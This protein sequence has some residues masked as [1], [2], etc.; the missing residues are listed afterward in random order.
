MY[1][2]VT[3]G[4]AMGV[5]LTWRIYANMANLNSECSE[6]LVFKGEYFQGNTGRDPLKFLSTVSEVLWASCPKRSSGKKR[7]HHPDR[8][9][10]FSS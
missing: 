4:V 1:G 3:R 6:V 10:Y 2:L 8:G 5:I 9:D 7:S